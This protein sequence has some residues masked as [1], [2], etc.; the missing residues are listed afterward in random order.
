MMGTTNQV[1]PAAVTEQP[2]VAN[3]TGEL[4]LRIG[5]LKEIEGVLRMVDSR[6]HKA[7]DVRLGPMPENPSAPQDGAP[8]LPGGQMLELTEVI[9]PLHL[10]A[11]SIAGAADRLDKL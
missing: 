4:A 8:S 5:Y 7:L 1:N 11:A 2:Q 6:L 3:E 10:V 9:D